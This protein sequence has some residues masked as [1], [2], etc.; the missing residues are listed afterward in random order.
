MPYQIN[1]EDIG[2]NI[3]FNESG[4]KYLDPN[5]NELKSV[6]SLL[7]LYKPEFDPNGYIIKAC[8]RKQNLSID[9]IRKKWDK[10]RD[11]ACERGHRLHSQLE[12]FVKTGD[13]LDSDYK[14]IVEEFKKIRFSGKLFSEV[15][16]FSSKFKIAGTT[17]LVELLDNNFVNIGDY[18]QNKKMGLKSKYGNKLL[19]PLDIF[20]EC[21]FEIYTFQMNLYSIMLNEHGYKTNKMTLY[22]VPPGGE[23]LEIFDVPK[24]R[25]ETLRLL[26]HYM[27]MRD[28]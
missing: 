7:S 17:D 19:Y 13:V 5:G 12:H 14:N 26:K 11:D 21:E 23:K 6:S 10:E 8:A 20:D 9:E 3:Q 27:A 25:R 28:W 2:K 4:H 22:Y 24:R 1:L 15:R 18:K 16:L